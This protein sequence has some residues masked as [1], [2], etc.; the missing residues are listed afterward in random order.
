MHIIS[1]KL[2]VTSPS[3][4]VISCPSFRCFP[5]TIELQISLRGRRH[6]HVL[7][8]A[9]RER[10]TMMSCRIGTTSTRYQSGVSSCSLYWFPRS[11]RTL[12]AYAFFRWQSPARLP[13][14]VFIPRVKTSLISMLQQDALVT[15]WVCG[16]H[17]LHLLPRRVHRGVPFALL[18]SR[19]RRALLSS[20]C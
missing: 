20:E 9:V 15:A 13:I 8:P 11:R 3:D 18:A 4:E 1:T 14:N 2:R 12:V 6:Q 17:T 7:R 19:L 5:R 16:T 10:G